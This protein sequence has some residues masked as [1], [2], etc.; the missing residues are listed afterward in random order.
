MQPDSE[1]PTGHR[2]TSAL[3]GAELAKEFRRIWTA[4]DDPPTATADLFPQR[5]AK[6]SATLL[7]V[8]G[9]GLSAYGARFR[10]PLGASD[11][12]ALLAERL[13]FTQGEG[14]CLA[15]IREQRSVVAD[16]ETLETRWP[17]YAA[18]L[19]RHTPYRAVMSLPVKTKDRQA[20]PDGARPAVRGAVRDRHEVEGPLRQEH[21]R[22]RAAGA[23]G[24][25]GRRPAALDRRA[26]GDRPAA[27]PSVAGDPRLR[28]AERPRVPPA[29]RAGRP[30]DR[31]ARR[32]LRARQPEAARRGGVEGRVRAGELRARHRRRQPGPPQ[33]RDARRG[34]EGEGAGGPARGPGRAGRARAATACARRRPRD[35][36]ALPDR[37]RRAAGRRGADAHRGSRR[38]DRAVRRR[39]APERAARRDGAEVGRGGS[40]GARARPLDAARRRGRARQGG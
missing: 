19:C 31:Q 7:N 1:A 14:P 25:H 29:R 37:S 26:G 6:A 33:L 13:Q 4:S 34:A 2:D 32:R 38:G 10:V 22:G 35:H 5:L 27:R 16:L 8:N 21:R 11:E 12:A 39:G 23:V 15:A 20:N 9:A 17:A 36:A 30:D 40:R 3:T 24:G 28:G 18:E